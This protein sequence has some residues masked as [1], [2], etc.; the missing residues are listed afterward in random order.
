MATVACN[1]KYDTKCKNNGKYDHV[2]LR[3]GSN[4]KARGAFIEM[5][6]NDIDLDVILKPKITLLCDFIKLHA[7]I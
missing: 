1:S 3:H 7:L 5:L 2:H 4:M 6:C